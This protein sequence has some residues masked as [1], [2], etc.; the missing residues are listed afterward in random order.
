LAVAGNHD[1]VVLPRLADALPP[2]ADVVHSFRLLGRDGGWEVADLTDPDG[3]LV[4]R[5]V[6]WSG[7]CGGTFP[8]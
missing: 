6:G 5:V 7:T 3:A 4:T 8:I 2:R 1:G